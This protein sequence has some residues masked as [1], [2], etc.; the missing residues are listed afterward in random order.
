MKSHYQFHKNFKRKGVLLFNFFTLSIIAFTCLGSTSATQAD[1]P[2]S[3]NCE[4]NGIKLYGKVE[5]VENFGDIKVE[6]V[7]NFGDIKVE[8]VENFADDCGEWEIVE[9]F[10]D[11]TIEIVENFGDIKVEKV[12]NFPGL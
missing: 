3:S 11:F 9:N 7:D 1:N 6:F 10:G 8:F 12:E 5:I 4:W 2:I